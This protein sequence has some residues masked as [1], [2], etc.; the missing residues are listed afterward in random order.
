MRNLIISAVYA[1]A[2]LIGMTA[3]DAEAPAAPYF[4][5][6]NK[7]PVSVNGNIEVVELFWYG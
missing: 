7:V 6:S 5:L 3:Q 2:I 4:E 1:A